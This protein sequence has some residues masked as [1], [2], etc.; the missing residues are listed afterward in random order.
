MHSYMH[1]GVPAH[2]PR[3]PHHPAHERNHPCNCSCTV[4]DWVSLDS[5]RAVPC[6]VCQRANQ[7]TVTKL[8][9]GLL[10]SFLI[11]YSIVMA[12]ESRARDKV[13]TCLYAFERH[14]VPSV[15]ESQKQE[16]VV[17]MPAPLRCMIKQVTAKKTTTTR[18]FCVR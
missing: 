1:T 12:P 11:G 2:I 14:S 5:F 10:L 15:E 16:L 9:K 7:P 4:I 3:K 6:V 18:T 17:W 8:Y 13:G